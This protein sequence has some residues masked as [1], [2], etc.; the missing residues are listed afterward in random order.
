MTDILHKQINLQK[1]SANTYAVSWHA[2]W[3]MGKSMKH[4]CPPDSSYEAIS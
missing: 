1:V 3:A 4:H 2:D